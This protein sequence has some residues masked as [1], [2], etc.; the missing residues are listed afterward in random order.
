MCDSLLCSLDRLHRD[1]IQYE[2]QNF[3]LCILRSGGGGSVGKGP[4]IV[5]GAPVLS[6]LHALWAASSGG[7]DKGLVIIGSTPVLIPVACT[8]GGRQRQ[9]C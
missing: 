2:P 7:V 4:A 6:Q 1:N 9:R 3:F 8:L 5:G